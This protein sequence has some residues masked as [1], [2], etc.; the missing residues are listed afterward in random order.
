MCPKG[1]FNNFVVGVNGMCL[2]KSWA[3]DADMI[4]TPNTGFIKGFKTV[5]VNLATD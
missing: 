2:N 3:N 4:L 1:L 5:F